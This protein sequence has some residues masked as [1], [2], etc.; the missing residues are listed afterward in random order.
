MQQI[1][2]VNGNPQAGHLIGYRGGGTGK[3]VRNLVAMY[4]SANSRMAQ[5]VEKYGWQSL[6]AG[7][8]LYISVIPYTETFIRPFPQRFR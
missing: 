5:K 2:A 7:N 8:S 1:A 6:S 4:G 3:D